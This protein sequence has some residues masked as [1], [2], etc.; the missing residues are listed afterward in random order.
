MPWGNLS[1][2]VGLCILGGTAYFDGLFGLF[3]R[4]KP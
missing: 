4:P 2:F 3:T 1:L